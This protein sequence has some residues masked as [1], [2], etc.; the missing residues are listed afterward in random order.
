MKR[1]SLLSEV[2]KEYGSN[3]ESFAEE[4]LHKISLLNLLQQ[5]ATAANETSDPESLLQFAI[6]RICRIADWE[7]GRGYLL[8][9]NGELEPVSVWYSREKD[10][11]NDLREVLELDGRSKFESI[12][13]RAEREGKPLW[14]EDLREEPQF[15]RIFSVGKTSVKS[16]YVIPIRVRKR[17]VGVLE[18]LFSA[19]APEAS[20]IEVLFNVCSQIGRVFERCESE[21]LLREAESHYRKFVE[22]IHAIFW[23]G[24]LKPLRVGYLSSEA[25]GLLGFRSVRWTGDDLSWLSRLHPAD[26]KKVVLC[27]ESL[28]E[29]DSIEIMFRIL[30]QDGRVL[31]FR[32]IVRAVK[33]KGIFPKLIGVMIDITE[34]KSV[35]EE[36]RSSREQLRALSARLQDAREDER[37]KISREVHDDLGQL[38]TALK[39]DIS[40]LR[41]NLSNDAKESARISRELKSMDGL[42]EKAIDSVRR[43]ATELRPLVLE[44]LG[45]L[46]GIRWFGR[47]FQDRTGIFL[48]VEKKG[49]DEKFGKD[50]SVALFRIFQETLTNVAR[51]SGASNVRV[52]VEGSE[53]DVV[54]TISDNGVG[55]SETDLVSSKSLGLIGMRERAIF[56]G[57]ELRIRSEQGGGTT[58][59]AKVPL[60][61]R[62]RRL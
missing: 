52:S 12:A 11:P 26:R 61:K 39:I 9:R 5:V 44:D 54:L 23:E 20:L 13:R 37:I 59:S 17:V 6:D 36:L 60:E 22:Q 62:G 2:G 25:E 21:E 19:S 28:S 46:E 18:F 7:L 27:L 41:G 14:V 57:G 15:D 47:D 50:I 56:L 29:G 34:Q 33:E 42:V 55:I 49:N 31:W 43:I 24:E 53:S 8:N 40:L 45:F 30:A 48:S 35:E 1:F 58:I 3:D 4:L 10:F 51:H 38:L 32:N 16:A